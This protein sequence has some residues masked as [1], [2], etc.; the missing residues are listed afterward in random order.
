M[1][2]I[3]QITIIHLLSIIVTANNSPNQ[4]INDQSVDGFIVFCI[5]PETPSSVTTGF[6]VWTHPNHSYN[7]H[8][9]NQHNIVVV[10]S[11]FFFSFFFLFLFFSFPSISQITTSYFALPL[12]FPVSTIPITTTHNSSTHTSLLGDGNKFRGS[13]SFTLMT[14]THFLLPPPHSC[15]FSTLVK[16]TITPNYRKYVEPRKWL[17]FSVCLWTVGRYQFCMWLA[18]HH[19]QFPITA[20]G[21]LDLDY[22][23]QLNRLLHDRRLFWQWQT[24]LYNTISV[25]LVWLECICQS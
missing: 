16:T 8:F 24:T 3:S 6:H 21:H 7:T 1:T 12:Q 11:F 10:V 9:I 23:I 13:V 2:D 19:Q 20:I 14:T 22:N 4:C 25:I 18:I 17:F 5:S 15:F